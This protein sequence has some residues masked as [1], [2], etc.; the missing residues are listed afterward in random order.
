MSPGEAR[1][2]GGAYAVNPADVGEPGNCKVES[3][4]SAAS[5]HDFFSAVT[6]ACVLGFAHPVEASLQIARTRAN[7]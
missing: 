4:M 5:N 3:W 2:A 7:E 6:P 1:A